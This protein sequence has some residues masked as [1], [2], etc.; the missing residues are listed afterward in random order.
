MSDTANSSHHGTP[1]GHEPTLVDFRTVVV[2]GI[3]LMVLVVSTMFFMRMLA[4]Y[5]S[6]AERAAGRPAA[7]RDAPLLAPLASEPPLSAAPAADLQSLR[8]AEDDALA[9][10]GWVD[11]EAGIA[12]IPIER[13]VQIFAES[14]MPAV[15]PTE[16]EK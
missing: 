3:A 2:A 10:Y 1:G 11:R 9:S 8:A 4:G 7:G 5:L 16:Q 13:A 15:L 14:R 12:R 6:A